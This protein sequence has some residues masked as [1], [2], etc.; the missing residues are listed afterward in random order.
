MINRFMR[1]LVMF[2]LP[3]DGKENKKYYTD[4]R[5]FLLRDGYD[6]IQFSVYSRICAN[7]DAV[8]KHL[9]RLRHVAPRKG[10]VRV[11]TITNKQ[12]GDAEIVT[13]ERRRQ[14]KRMNEA[15]ISL[16]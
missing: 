5:K 2:D 4:F 1:M 16:F 11:I 8:D 14:E 12:Y 10:A 9:K 15:Q 7:L 13:G 6:M 3:T